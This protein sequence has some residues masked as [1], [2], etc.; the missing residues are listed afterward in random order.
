MQNHLKHLQDRE[1]VLRLHAA[2]HTTG[3]RHAGRVRN[4]TFLTAKLFQFSLLI[5][6]DLL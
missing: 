3:D 4:P 2:A 6:L 5:Q 1:H